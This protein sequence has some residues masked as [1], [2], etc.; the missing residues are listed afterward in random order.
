M[1]KLSAEIKSKLK[2]PIIMDKAFKNIDR[3]LS[4]NATLNMAICIFLI[5]YLA[6]DIK[7]YI[8]GF[9]NNELVRL[10]VIVVAVY[11]ILRCNMNKIS[12]SSH[13]C[14]AGILLLL[15]A[16]LHNRSEGFLGG[17]R[18]YRC[19][20]QWEDFIKRGGSWNSRTK[21]SGPYIYPGVKEIGQ[22][23]RSSRCNP[24]R[25]GGKEGFVG[26]TYKEKEDTSKKYLVDVA[27]AQQAVNG[28][29]DLQMVEVNAD[30][31]PIDNT[32]QMVE[33]DAD[34]N[35]IDNGQMVEVN[36]D[37]NPIDNNEPAAG[38]STELATSEPATDMPGGGGAQQQVVGIQEGEYASL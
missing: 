31:N 10:V 24:K 27:Q 36:A 37:G 32:G 19:W 16:V 34:G 21:R 20:L 8:P 11:L 14:T 2:V 17:G 33:V 3:A 1:K 26:T 38:P 25:G 22:W 13:A 9:L 35:P 7:D 28:D 4:K 30:G 12:A 15:A 5:V 6:F 29:D 23:G 18:R